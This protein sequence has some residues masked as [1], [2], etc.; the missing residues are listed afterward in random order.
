MMKTRGIHLFI[1]D[2]SLLNDAR[3][4]ESVQSWLGKQADSKRLALHVPRER[5]TKRTG[6]GQGREDASLEE[7]VRREL[8]PRYA[9]VKG[10][11][12]YYA[13]TS[14]E[15]FELGSAAWQD[16]V[17]ALRAHHV[18][19]QKPS[20]SSREDARKTS[21][22]QQQPSAGDTFFEE[23][24]SNAARCGDDSDKGC[25]HSL[26]R[27][28]FLEAFAKLAV[29]LAPALE[30]AAALRAALAACECLPVET[31]A[32]S[33][34]FHTR[35]W[36]RETEA[37]LL[38]RKELLERVFCVSCGGKAEDTPQ[39]PAHKHR[40]SCAQWL[41][42]ARNA[43]LVD[44][45]TRD[46]D[47]GLHIGF[48]ARECTLAFL[49]AA[50]TQRDELETEQHRHLKFIDFVEALLRVAD[51][52]DLSHTRAQLQSQA[53]AQTW[54]QAASR[55]DRASGDLLT[56]MLPCERLLTLIDGH[57]ATVVKPDHPKAP[58]KLPGAS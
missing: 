46:D 52:R 4:C 1:F 51:A 55:A 14:V 53:T 24:F 43:G 56:D 45:S 11:F 33:E 37:L 42:F 20:S 5:E 48:S 12:K 32:Q 21:A 49:R 3:A 26:M 36:S 17:T 15:V 31:L 16:F 25:K 34:A 30:P 58:T 27:F 39:T 38:E 50:Q 8:R 10:C 9:L 13:S 7:A 6:G 2:E 44:D 29:R 28:Q 22:A 40:M 23:I 35:M 47:E 19:A 18:S 57:I 54:H 41:R